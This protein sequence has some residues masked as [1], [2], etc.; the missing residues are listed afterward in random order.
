MPNPKGP[1]AADLGLSDKPCEARETAW[2]PFFLPGP[3]PKCARAPLI[4][5]AVKH[6]AGVAKLGQRRPT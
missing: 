4:R 3:M 1:G 6:H 5:L 2:Q